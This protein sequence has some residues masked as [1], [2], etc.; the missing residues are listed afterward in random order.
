M[1]KKDMILAAIRER[2]VLPLY[3]HKDKEVSKKV[4]K[5][6]YDAGIRTIEYTNR[7]EAA[8]EN[9]QLLRQACDEEFKGMYLGAG[10]IT[11]AGSA[12]KF[13][14]AGVDFMVCPGLV[15]Q[16]AA[17]AAEQ[18]ILWVPGCMTPSEIIAADHLGA[19]LIKLFPGNLLGPSFVS[20]IRPVFRHLSFMPTGGADVTAENLEG[21]FNA[22]VCAVGMGSKLISKDLLENE[23]YDGITN[24]T[25]Q[26]LQ[27]IRS[28]QRN[29]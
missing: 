12:E 25:R 9:F 7:G 15:Q 5:A 8:L 2:G 27:L 21:W 26:V 6:L 17:T 10:T 4:L 13:V 24:R 11:D 22:G 19:Q 18:N 16:V 23:D 3:F 1:D 14:D 20:A 29:T 28:L